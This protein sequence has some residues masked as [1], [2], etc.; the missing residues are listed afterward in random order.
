M[1]INFMYAEAGQRV[2]DK[3]P[4]TDF[5]RGLQVPCSARVAGSSRPAQFGANFAFSWQ[6]WH[7]IKERTPST[8]KY[9]R[10]AC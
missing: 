5:G 4:C 6:S 1:H 10:R 9:L 3:S 2:Y 8:I 7:P